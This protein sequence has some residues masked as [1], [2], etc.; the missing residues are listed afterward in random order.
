MD[1]TAL[2]VT[3]EQLLELVVDKIVDDITSGYDATDVLETARMRAEEKKQLIA[4]EQIDTYLERE[5]PGV[6]DAALNSTLLSRPNKKWGEPAVKVSFQQFA[7]E[8][9]AEWLTEKV[10]YE[11]RVDNY[12]QG[13][14]QPRI[15]YLIHHRL[16]DEIERAVGSVMKDAHTILGEG[17]QAVV[18]NSLKRIQAAVSVQVKQS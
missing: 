18:T 9:M 8:R 7:C 10:N 3:K 2:G 13:N 11:G 16:K 14:N 17:I 1:L 12:G 15:V 6:L 5:L 4:Q